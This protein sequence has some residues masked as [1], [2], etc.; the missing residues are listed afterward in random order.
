LADRLEP[1][2]FP[3]RTSTSRLRLWRRLAAVGVVALLAA[4][5][6]VIVLASHGSDG[7]PPLACD[8][9]NVDFQGS[10]AFA[11]IVNEVAALYEGYCPGANITVTAIGSG[12]GLADLTHQTTGPPVVAMSDGQP[13]SGSPGPE[14]V[15]TPVGVIIFAV[16]GNTQL[17]ARLF[18]AGPGN[19]MTRQQI[20]QA[21]AYPQKAA[22]LLSVPWVAPVGR[23]TF[24]GAR[25]AFVLDVLGGN[26]TAELTAGPCLVNENSACL[27][28][29]TTDLLSYVNDNLYTIGYAEADALF[30]FPNVGAIPINGY[31]PT[32][33]NALTGHYTFLATEYL[34]TKGRPAGLAADF[35]NFLTSSAVTAELRSSS[36]FISC[37]DLRGSNLS[38]TCPPA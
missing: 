27:E 35:I 26:D 31:A 17:P 34:Y 11:P 12:Q 20:A 30:D 15:A 28:D 36:S 8:P 14:Y 16:V 22:K 13:I 9:G 29:T 23:S 4:S 33:A 10:T 5:V 7:V 2:R 6:L 21:F 3:D 24:S 1:G 37:S 32:R 25:Q 18:T 38:R 19:G